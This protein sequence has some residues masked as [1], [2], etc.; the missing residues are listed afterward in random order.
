MEP[1]ELMPL[2]PGL[3]K[4][5]EAILVKIRESRD[6]EQIRGLAHEY[7]TTSLEYLEPGFNDNTISKKF[8]IL[9]NYMQKHPL[10]NEIY[11]YHSPR[12]A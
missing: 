9:S 11:D 1:G 5:L 12:A 7:R 3:E 10:V 2:P 4:N 8:K 6:V